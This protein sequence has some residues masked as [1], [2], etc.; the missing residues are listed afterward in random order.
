MY[1]PAPMNKMFRADAN[2]A[3]PFAGKGKFAPASEIVL[4]WGA[5]AP[6]A[7]EGTSAPDNVTSQIFSFIKG[8]PSLPANQRLKTEGAQTYQ[9]QFIGLD[10]N[11][12]MEVASAD[13]NGD[14]YDDIIT[15]Y[16]TPGKKAFL[17]L[18]LLDKNTLTFVNQDPFGVGIGTMPALASPEAG[19]GYRSGWWAG[20]RG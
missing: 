9:G 18:S 12:N 17:L 2:A 11:E 4:L 19:Q 14:G 6:G 15:L 20:P 5:P 13:F 3:G 8:Q 1:K 10:G 16:E 7:E